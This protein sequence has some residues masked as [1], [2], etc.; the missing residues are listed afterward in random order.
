MTQVHFY[1]HDSVHVDGY[2][3]IVSFNDNEIVLRC[4]KNNLII[5]G[6]KLQIV[7]FNGMEISVRGYI[8]GVRWNY[9]GEKE[10]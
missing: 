8:E 7:S 10:V 3:N 4:K 1:N 6:S 9:E 2:R 5:F